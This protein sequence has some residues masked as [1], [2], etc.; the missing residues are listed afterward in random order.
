MLPDALQSEIAPYVLADEDTIE[1]QLVKAADRLA[2]YVKCMEE[3]RYGNGEFVK[4][5]KSIEEDL[6]SRNMP[7]IEYFFENFMPSFELT[8]DE[9]EDF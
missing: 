8:L 4:A 3:L 2:A 9:L 6:H 1:Y 7:E 5:K